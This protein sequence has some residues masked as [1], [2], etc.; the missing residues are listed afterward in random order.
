MLSEAER[1]QFED[2]TSALEALVAERT[3][4]LAATVKELEAFTYSVAHDL[5]APVRAIHGFSRALLEDYGDRFEGES[6]DH[7]LRICRASERMSQ[8]IDDLLKLSRVGR[9]DIERRVV[10]LSALVAGIGSRLAEREPARD[11]TLDI[12]PGVVVRGD[13]RLLTIALENVLDNA[14]KF[15]RR[16]E[17]AVIRFFTAERDG[18]RVVCVSDN[19]TGFD[20]RY[21]D[22]LFAPFQRLH[23]AEDFEGTGIGLVT[24]ARILARHGGDASIEGVEGHGATVYLFIPAVE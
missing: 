6:L 13:A 4:E 8:L 20:M 3:R 9:G 14:W 5:R 1:A 24:I 22:K 16:R 19:G 21:R 17:R 12:E 2:Q 15:T 11:V 10:D 23:R 18:R 7:M